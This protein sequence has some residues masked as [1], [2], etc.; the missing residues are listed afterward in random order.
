MDDFINEFLDKASEFIAHKPGVL[1]MVGV[2]L[3]LVNLII[4]MIL[5]ATW[6][7]V[8]SHVVLHIGLLFT[9]IGLLLINPL[10]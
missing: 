7:I 9:L 6:W 1:P 3:I 5:P 10:K 8:R 4:Q 2:I